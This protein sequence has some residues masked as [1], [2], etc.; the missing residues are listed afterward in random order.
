MKRVFIVLTIIFI[1]R[2][3]FSCCNCPDDVSSINYNEIS[4]LNV[5]NALPYGYFDTTMVDTLMNSAVAFE[6]ILKDSTQKDTYYF[7]QHFGFSTANA[8]QPCD[9]FPMFKAK[10]E[11]T[12]I[13]IT[14]LFDMN[15][16]IKANT[17]VSH[18]FVALPSHTFLYSS[19]NELLPILND[20]ILYI[21]AS[22]SFK[23]FC[24]EII[25]NDVA[26]FDIQ[27]DLSDGSVLLAKTNLVQL[28]QN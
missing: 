3:F 16:T 14:T 18:Y 15:E 17:E 12:K 13:R 2:L 6:I 11:I 27:V 5:N 10:Q 26:Q 22:I 7:V 4:I 9:C 24:K 28:I 1:S 20:K 19:I 21:S 25:M 8:M 23:I